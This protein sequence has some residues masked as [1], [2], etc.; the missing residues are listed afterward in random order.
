MQSKFEDRKCGECGSE[1]LAHVAE[2]YAGQIPAGIEG[3]IA[4]RGCFYWEKVLTVSAAEDVLD[5]RHW[6]VLDAGRGQ[7]HDPQEREQTIIYRN[8]EAA[9]YPRF[10]VE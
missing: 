7:Y 10:G 6:V 1:D 2:W 4:C 3:E 5:T 8:P 9:N